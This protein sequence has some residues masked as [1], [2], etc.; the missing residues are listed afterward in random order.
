MLRRGGEPSILASVTVDE[1]RLAGVRRALALAAG[2][3]ASGGIPVARA[4]DLPPAGTTAAV[5]TLE[6]FLVWHAPAGCSTAAAVRERVRELSGEPDLEL[7]RV[8]RVEGSVRETASGWA[9]ELTLLT[10]LGQRKRQLESPH[11]ADLAE[12]AA[13][14]ITLALEAARSHEPFPDNERA[15]ADS[16]DASSAPRASA[17]SDGPQGSSVVPD[18]SALEASTP[19]APPPARSNGSVW[20][21]AEL[22]LD[23][24]FLPAPA[25]GPSL[26]A[27]W[28][29]E[30][31]QLGAY[32]AWLPGSERSLGP[33]QSVAFS[34][35]LGGVRACY[36]LGHG[37]LDTALCAGLEAGRLSATGSGLLG[38]RRANDPWLAPQ[39]GLELGAPV[40]EL[41]VL[42]AR[43][44]AIAPLLRQGY[45]VNDT[46]AVHRVASVGLRAAVGLL[47]AF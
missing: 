18:T 39:L 4:A 47:L 44:D 8:R 42:H 12:A 9:L 38:A 30:A 11:C 16:E 41:V 29:W 26:L 17:A 13:V 32:A 2:L 22:L 15:R 25:P 21:G 1:R 37:L 7:G 5:D 40:S 27:V 45:A 3:S 19:G 28:R 24:S 23:V 36:A 14:A 43:V 46:E 33:G 6:P 35:L 10:V 20:L 31:L 34:L